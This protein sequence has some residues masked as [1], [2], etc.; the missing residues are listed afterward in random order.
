VLE[1]L[2]G[3]RRTLVALMS[4]FIAPLAAAFWLYYGTGWRPAATI[5]HGELIVPVRTLPQS[6]RTQVANGAQLFHD[7][8]W[9]LVIVSNDGCGAECQSALKNAALTVSLLGRLQTRTQTVLVHGANCCDADL[10]ALGQRDLIQLDA[11]LSPE[12]LQAFPAAQRAQMIFI[13]DPLGNLLMRYDS[14]K[15]PRGLLDDLK[16]LLDLSQI[17]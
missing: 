5:N 2:Q 13:V 6:A 17:G 8:K 3:G 15:D 11:T 16:R 7:R 9:S 1:K 4:L 14:A 10:E 12:L